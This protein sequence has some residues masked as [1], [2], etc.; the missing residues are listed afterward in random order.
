[1]DATF[2]PVLGAGGF[3]TPFLVCGAAISV[4]AMRLVT[5]WGCVAGI[6]HKKV[7]EAGEECGVQH[8]ARPRPDAPVLPPW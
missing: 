5:T 8:Q 3:I 4:I 7:E 6:K 2:G 1:M